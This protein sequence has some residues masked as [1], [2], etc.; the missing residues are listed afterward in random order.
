MIALVTGGASG[1]GLAFAKKLADLG[2]DLIIVGRTL[3]T[4]A[5]AQREIEEKYKVRVQIFIADITKAEARE[6]LYDYANNYDVSV[7]VNNAGIGLSKDFI[8]SS[9]EEDI[10]VINLNI[11]ALQ[12]I[13]KHYYKIFL[14]KKT[15]RIINISSLAGFVPGPGASTYY[16]SKAYVTSLT[17]AVFKEAKAHNVIIQAV[18]PG[19]TKS[20]FHAHAGTK[21]KAYRQD[22]HKLAIK[23]LESKRVVVIVGFKNKLIHFFSKFL[24]Q[25]WLAHFSY[26]TQKRI[27]IKWQVRNICYNNINH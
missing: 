2:Y 26:K 4:L 10:E 8:D 15:G 7:V 21:A 27:R 13:M 6:R 5:A 19:P 25:S 14:E 9:I 18:C 3:D 16:A 17:R 22:P 20:N 12:H 11:I 24:P 23:A 1:I